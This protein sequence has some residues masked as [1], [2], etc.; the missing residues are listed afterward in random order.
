MKR[1]GLLDIAMT[2]PIVKPPPK[3]RVIGPLRYLLQELRMVVYVLRRDPKHVHQAA[4]VCMDLLEERGLDMGCNVRGPL[5]PP[6]E[7]DRLLEWFAGQLPRVAQ[8]GDPALL[9][10]WILHAHKNI[11]EERPQKVIMVSP[12]DVAQLTKED[13]KKLAAAQEK[14][15]RRARKRQKEHVF[16]VDEFVRKVKGESS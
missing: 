12:S 14:K 11:G 13:V 1:I 2:I 9:F 16:D 3:D 7:G 5:D 4:A 10:S 6:L 8:T 15:D